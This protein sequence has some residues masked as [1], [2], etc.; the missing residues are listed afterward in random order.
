MDLSYQLFK[1]ASFT[2]KNHLTD[3]V[4]EHFRF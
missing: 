4:Q 2:V 1:G 3:E